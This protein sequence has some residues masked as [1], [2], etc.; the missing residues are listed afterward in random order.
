MA[1]H[2]ICAAMIIHRALA[3][4]PEQLT[5]SR[6]DWSAPPG[7][8]VPA[9]AEQELGNLGSCA[10]SPP[11]FPAKARNPVRRGLSVSTAATAFVH[12]SSTGEVPDLTLH[13]VEPQKWNRACHPAIDARR[14]KSCQV[15]TFSRAP[16][17]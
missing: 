16:I 4:G 12:R 6:G 7:C 2:A 11:S 14:A 5:I 17:A 9:E 8:R 15:P 1:L 3:H 13:G 10:I